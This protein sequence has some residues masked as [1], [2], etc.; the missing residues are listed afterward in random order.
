MILRFLAIAGTMA[1]TIGS[2]NK[3]TAQISPLPLVST[4][5][6][7]SHRV[8]E[9]EYTKRANPFILVNKISDGLQHNS[10]EA[11]QEQQTR[12][13]VQQGG[14]AAVSTLAIITISWSIRRWQKHLSKNENKSIPSTS[15]DTQPITTLLNQKQQQHLQE[16]K[17]RLFQT[18]QVMLWGGG[19]L[20][21]LGLFPYTKP[22]QIG[23]LAIAKIPIKLTIVAVGT[24]VAIRFTYALID[25]FTSTIVSGG[26]LLTPET[27][28]RL[29]L[30]IS[31]F[32]GVTKSITTI[33]WV[34]TGSLLALTS[35][36][37]NIVPLL[38]SAGL[39]G[40]ALSLPS[41]NLI[42]DAIN[43]FLIIF[44]D[45]YALGDMITVGTVGGLVEKL[46][47]RMTQVRDSEGRLITIPNSE[48]KIVA[49][50]SSRWSRADLTIPVSYQ[51]NVD[52]ALKLI[53]DV[54]LDMTQDPQWQDQILEKPNVLG[55]DNFSD[56]GIMIRILIKTQPLK[57][58]AVAREYRRRLKITLDA[59]GIY[60]PV[61]QQANWVNEV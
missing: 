11:N 49:N 47:L 46:N 33:I 44:E 4:A 8:D 36:G 21:I 17:K 30:R 6:I 40:V 15:T 18:A 35:L 43:G 24:Y 12:F 25:H 41:Q 45:Q 23:I 48:V 38:A 26:A 27:S 56:R 34:G 60:I 55:I 54:G 53:E 14:I 10:K 7:L 58:W 59:A 51:A 2:V 32:S 1:I 5:S 13:L 9:K 29:Q 42:K 3:A 39:L 16:V 19:T 22:L 20:I 37:I 57:Q 52:E 50:L 31:T 28:A 61:P